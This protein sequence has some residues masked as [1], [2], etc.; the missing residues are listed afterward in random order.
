MTIRQYI[1]RKVPLALA[2]G[3]P[4]VLA[5]FHFRK[6]ADSW[7]DVGL[8]ILMFAWIAASW[9]YISIRCP[10][11][12]ADRQIV[13]DLH[14]FDP[15][16]YGIVF[17]PFCGASATESP[18]LSTACC[19]RCDGFLFAFFNFRSFAGSSLRVVNYC[20]YCGISFDAKFSEG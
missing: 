17:C 4:A 15:G 10:R 9:I 6:D 1:T 16:K 12:K 3:S 2:A 11:C 7:G 19:S 13:H 14:N 18:G 5:L 8:Y 20:R